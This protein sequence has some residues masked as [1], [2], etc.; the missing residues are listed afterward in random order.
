MASKPQP[1]MLSA[2]IAANEFM[3]GV[4]C[5]CKE[6]ACQCQ[7]LRCSCRKEG[8]SCVSAC[9]FFYVSYS[10]GEAMMTVEKDMSSED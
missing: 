6:G 5:N 9:M 7:T 1:K 8:I 3:K 10:N 4:Y 2:L